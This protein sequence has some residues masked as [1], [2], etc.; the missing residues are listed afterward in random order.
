MNPD[1]SFTF[2]RDIRGHDGSTI[3]VEVHLRIVSYE[4]R[5]AG[6]AVLHDISERRQFESERN[7]LLGQIEKNL[8]ELAILN[9]G[10]RN[11]LSVISSL[12]E[13]EAPGIEAKVQEQIRS[14]DEMVK[15]LDMRWN[16]SEKVLRFLRLHYQIGQ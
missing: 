5:N 13:E 12:V 14:I 2:Y 4:G 10:I 15:N 3:P 8:G 1:S 9:D 6:L 7:A 11:P 16:E